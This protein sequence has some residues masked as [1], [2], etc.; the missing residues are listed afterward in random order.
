[1]SDLYIALQ[2][3][4][5]DLCLGYDLAWTSLPIEFTIFPRLSSKALYLR[6]RP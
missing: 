3:Q 5:L 4:P 6:G 1:M 2:C